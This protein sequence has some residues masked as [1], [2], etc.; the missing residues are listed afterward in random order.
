MRFLRCQKYF[1]QVATFE[2]HCRKQDQ[3]NNIQA[4]T[5]Y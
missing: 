4:E 3:T 1:T 5:F 2:K